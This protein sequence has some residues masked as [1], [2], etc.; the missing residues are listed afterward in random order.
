MTGV[1][2]WIGL[3]NM[4]SRMAANLAGSGV[5]LVV[6]DRHSTA[7]AP[8]GSRIAADNAA[9]GQAAQV[10]FLCVPAG[11]DT[12]EVAADLLGAPERRVQTVVDTSTIGIR[13]AREAAQLLAGHGIAYVDA[14][15]SGGIAG[16]QAATLAVMASCPAA[17]MDEVRPLLETIGSN[18]FHVGPEP[19][20][21][22]TIK[23]LNNFLSA[24]AMAATSEAMT[25]ATA[26]GLDLQATLDV[27][28]VSSGRNT[29]TMDK[30][31]NR[32]VPGGYD[33]G[34]ASAMMAKDV[35]LYLENVRGSGTADRIGAVVADIYA[36]LDRDEPG[37]DS[38][39]IYAHTRAGRTGPDNG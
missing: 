19:G 24:T 14:P 36:R 32:I 22:Q 15:V 23:L 3:G 5:E 31:P 7:R 30:F 9:V 17:T 33:G 34:F 25:F 1:I 28:N 13:H 35:R 27:V 38:T 8:E 4:G 12:L 37:S 29:A 6:A 21:G 16:A 11:P 10:V 39:R 26:N 18:V 2:G 20:Q